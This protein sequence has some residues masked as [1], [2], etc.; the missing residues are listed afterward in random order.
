MKRF[1]RLVL[2]ALLALVAA[3]GALYEG[4]IRVPPD[5][6]PWG[7]VMLD[8]KP[9][10]FANIQL[11]GLSTDGAACRAALGRTAMKFSVMADRK[12]GEDCGFTN[13]VRADATSIAMSPRPVATCAMTA[14]LYWWQQRLDAI[15]QAELHSRVVRIDQLGTYA[16]RNINSAAEGRRSQHATANAIDIAAFHLA[17]GRVISVLKDYG[18]PTPEGRFLDAAHDEACGLFNIVLG[19][20]YN[21]LHAN[22]FHLDLGG[23]RF[24]R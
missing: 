11:N 6:F 13:V 22:H 2:F 15:A 18:K 20:D 7:P 17:D 14:G 9:G 4:W 12:I 5:L 21:R 16:C 3:G 24:C 23:F 8:R 10:W 1:R 19:P